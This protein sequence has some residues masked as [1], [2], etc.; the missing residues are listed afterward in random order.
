MTMDYDG[1]DLASLLWWDIIWFC[2]QRRQCHLPQPG[3]LIE[4]AR[5]EQQQTLSG[6][7]GEL[8]E[9]Q[10]WDSSL[11]EAE[12]VDAKSNL[13]DPVLDGT[14]SG[15][16]VYYQIKEGEGGKLNDYSGKWQRSYFHRRCLL[17]F[18][19]YYEISTSTNTFRKTYSL[20]DSGKVGDTSLGS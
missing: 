2:Y 9:V 7:P 8:S 15:L 14:E 18:P 19:R 17:G 4:L 3:Q 1:S 6:L 5:W 20:P 11:S 16:L 12:I 10:I 13:L